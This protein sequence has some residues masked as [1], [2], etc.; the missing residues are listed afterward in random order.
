MRSRLSRCAKVRS[1]CGFSLAEGV[2]GIAVWDCIIGVFVLFGSISTIFFLYQDRKKEL[3]KSMADFIT[4]VFLFIRAIFGIR[5]FHRNFRI[6]LLKKYFMVRVIWTC[7][8]FLTNLI[9]A[10]VDN[11]TYQSFVFNMIT[12]VAFDIILNLIIWN[13]L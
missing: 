7:L 9:L 1:C 4:T 6:D 3:S 2:H 13:F 8:V 10:A 12:L 5:A 11:V